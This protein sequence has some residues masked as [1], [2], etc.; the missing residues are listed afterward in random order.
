V[1]ELKTIRADLVVPGHGRALAWPDAI[2]PEERYLER[3]LAD[4]RAAI[5]AKRTLAET[6]TALDDGRG[7]WLLYDDF[8]RRNVTAAYAELEWDE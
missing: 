8:H 4:V 6:I 7:A 2:A 3:L 1:A 5:R